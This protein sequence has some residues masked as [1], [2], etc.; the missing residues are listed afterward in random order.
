[1]HTRTHVHTHMHGCTD[2]QAH[3]PLCFLPRYRCGSVH[4]VPTAPTSHSINARPGV[5]RLLVQGKWKHMLLTHEALI[6]SC[7]QRWVQQGHCQPPRSTHWDPSILLWDFAGMPTSSAGQ[8]MHARA[9]WTDA[10]KNWVHQDHQSCF[11]SEPARSLSQVTLGEQVPTVRIHCDNSATSAAG[12]SSGN[13][14]ESLEKRTPLTFPKSKPAQSQTPEWLP[15][16]T[17]VYPFVCI[18]WFPTF[19]PN[20][21]KG[22]AILKAMVHFCHISH[23][24]RTR[25]QQKSCGK[26]T[27]QEI[28]NPIS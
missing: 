16:G 14:K 19:T 4:M 7:G 1:M 12:W 11:P 22:Q 18:S 10:H 9:A 5:W 21:K 17:L 28:S 2:S 25:K 8:A 3:S 26:V 27:S 15:G 6:S 24:F 20:Q 13:R 23:P